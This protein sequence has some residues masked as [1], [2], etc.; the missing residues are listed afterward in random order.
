MPDRKSCFTKHVFQKPIYYLWTFDSVGRNY[1]ENIQGTAG[2][3]LTLS[4]QVQQLEA[5]GEIAHELI[6]SIAHDLIQNKSNLQEKRNKREEEPYTA[7]LDN[8]GQIRIPHNPL[9]LRRRWWASHLSVV[10]PSPV[11]SQYFSFPGLSILPY[12]HQYI[13][14]A[15]EF[16]LVVF[17]YGGL[18]LAMQ[19]AWA[20]LSTLGWPGPLTYNCPHRNPGPGA[21]LGFGNP[22]KA[23]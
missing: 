22:Q 8:S 16:L 19:A 18:Q 13:I 2:W 1:T 7:P 17:L 3:A 12:R 21:G 15:T 6:Q 5:S 9:L 14:W 20:T 4:V 10:R 23:W 11:L